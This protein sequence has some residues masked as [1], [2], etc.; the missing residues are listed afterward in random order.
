MGLTLSH[1]GNRAPERAVNSL[2]M[3]MSSCS[4]SA[5]LSNHHPCWA[6]GS[7]NGQVQGCVADWLVVRC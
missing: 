4:E 5:T 7:G 6:A 2:P 3:G 1:S